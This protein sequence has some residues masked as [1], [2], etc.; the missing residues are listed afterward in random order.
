V[1]AH[2]DTAGDLGIVFGKSW[3]CVKKL[4]PGTLGAAVGRLE[5]GCR[6]VSINETLVEGMEFSAAGPLVKARPVTLIFAPPADPAAPHATGP[7]A[8]TRG[9]SRSMLPAVGGAARSLSRNSSGGSGG[10]VRGADGCA[11]RV[12]PA[13]TRPST[14]W[15]ALVEEPE[16][17]D[18]ART[19]SGS[20]YGSQ[21]ERPS[22]PLSHGSLD[23]TSSAP[24]SPVPPLPA[25]KAGLAADDG[26]LT[27]SLSKLSTDGSDG[28]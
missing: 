5:E 1:K 16:V 27:Q 19:S 25:G 14:A 8:V 21:L 18:L 3:P 23:R 13:R 11:P 7:R 20:S 6:L 10:L 12:Q 9:R 24:D 17:V 4:K 26:E 22:P 2:F 28:A 15:Q